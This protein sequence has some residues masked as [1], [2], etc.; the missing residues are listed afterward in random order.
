MHHHAVAEEL[1][2]R[3]AAGAFPPGKR[4][5]TR[6]DLANELG[7]SSVTLQ[8]AF[9]RLAEQGFLDIRGKQG[10]FV[11]PHPPHQGRVA[12][13]FGDEVGHGGWNRFWSN[14]L[15]EGSAWSDGQGRRFEA[16]LIQGGDMRSAEHQRLC[17]DVQD[18]GLSGMF[19]V[20]TPWFLTGSPV[21]S[22]PLPRAS[23]SLPSDIGTAYGSILVL[24]RDKSALVRHF[25]KSGRRRLAAICSRATADDWRSY[26]VE[27][28]SAGLETKRE[29]WLGLPV[30]P[31][32]A[33]CARTVTHLL[34]TA[35]PASR[36]DALLI[37]DDNLVPHATAGLQD[38]GIRV[39]DDVEV[40]AYA[41]LP[42]ATLAA[43]S[44]RRFGI[45]LR[46][47]LGAALDDLDRQRAG[48]EPRSIEIPSAI[49]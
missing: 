12:L 47:L 15:R 41:N 46:F 39:P 44:C 4:I 30:D 21:L 34:F 26:A 32:W 33:D 31:A 40:L 43:V 29:W 20:S 48:G 28:Q 5:P 38:A 49:V 11:V 25:L 9:H 18:G 22:S 45:D 27:A 10:T 36:P 6:R 7:I 8:R 24:V 23:I 2:R 19:F 16:Y 1:R 14:M 37:D 42:Q 13:V 3:I 35:P 17:R